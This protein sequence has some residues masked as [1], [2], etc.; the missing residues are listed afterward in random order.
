MNYKRVKCENLSV[1]VEKSQN[2]HSSTVIA[3]FPRHG[4]ALGNIYGQTFDIWRTTAKWNDTD[5]GR[6]KFGAEA[7]GC[8]L[9]DKRAADADK[10]AEFG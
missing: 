3:P 4:I 5:F 9:A 10:Y 1:K 7:N 2:S 8:V 6:K